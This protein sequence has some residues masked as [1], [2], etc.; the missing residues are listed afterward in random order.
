MAAEHRE[1]HNVMFPPSMWARLSEE[2]EAKYTSVST[3]VLQA[4]NA[5]F[6]KEDAR[7]AKEAERDSY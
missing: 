2:A 7:E 1:R 3:I 4:V 6:K 5:H